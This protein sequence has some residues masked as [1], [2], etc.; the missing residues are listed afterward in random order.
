MDKSARP[1][2]PHLTIYRWPITML[3][4]ILH[5]VTGVALSVGLLLV[6]ITLIQ[7][8]AGPESYQYLRNVMTTLVGKLLLIGWTLA[9]FIHLGN[10]IRHIVWDTGHGLDADRL[11]G[12]AW[13]VLIAAVLLTAGFWLTGS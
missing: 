7:A 10:G 2:S 12:P 5:R 1:T 8:A 13:A 11:N 3:V 4:S 6:T 9:F